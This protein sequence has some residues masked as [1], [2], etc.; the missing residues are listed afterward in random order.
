[1]NVFERQKYIGNGIDLKIGEND[2]FK[3]A[4]PEDIEHYL[5]KN[6]IGFNS[7]ENFN[8]PFESSYNFKHYFWSHEERN[9]F[10]FSEDKLEKK[11]LVSQVRTLIKNRLDCLSISC[12]SLTPYEPLMWA[13]YANY[14]FGICL[15]FERKNLFKTQKAVHE[16]VR[17][18]NQLPTIDFFEGVST[19]STL[20]PQ[21][22][23]IILT[24]SLN[25]AYEKEYRFFLE[26]N[27]Q[28]LEFN[29]ASLNY[30]ILGCRSKEDENLKILLEKFNEKHKTNVKLLY[31][32]KS[33]NEY[34]ML[35]FDKKPEPFENYTLP[36]YDP[37]EKPIS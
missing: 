2:V 34:R 17:Y 9:S 13:H 8:D 21:I 27:I 22:D 15:C 20:K 11:N 6:T 12:F 16:K 3:F 24:K 33:L 18:S 28:F 5:V 35:V 31:A 37:N 7:I 1:M 14:H 36:V 4:K 25:W 19:K 10:C 29:P 32:S 30:I 23:E 26:D